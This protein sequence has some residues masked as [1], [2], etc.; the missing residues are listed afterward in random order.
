MLQLVENGMVIAP[1]IRMNT[2]NRSTR[3]RKVGAI[4]GK[5]L[6]AGGGGFLL[7][8]VPPSEHQAVRQALNELVCVPFRLKKPAAKSSR[9]VTVDF[10]AIAATAV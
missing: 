7:L 3:A 9:T 8:C 10:S 1:S 4:G 5:L 2:L 6:G